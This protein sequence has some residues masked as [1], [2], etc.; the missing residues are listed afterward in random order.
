MIGG[1]GSAG[2]IGA[3]IFAGDAGAGSACSAGVGSGTAGGG[4]IPVIV[5]EIGAAVGVES[6]GGVGDSG[7]V[8]VGFS[9]AGA[10]AVGMLMVGALTGGTAGNV[11]V[12]VAGNGFAVGIGVNGIG[13]L[14][15][16]GCVVVTAGVVV[17]GVVRS[18]VDFSIGVGVCVGVDSEVGTTVDAFSTVGASSVISYWCA[19][20]FSVFDAGAGV[21]T[22]LSVVAVAPCACLSSAIYDS[23][24]KIAALQSLRCFSGLL[25]GVALKT[26]SSCFFTKRLRI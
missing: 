3:V 26:S 25:K 10:D 24:A 4:V 21:C 2:G 13:G 18:G 12:V 11:G 14:V 17:D 8:A 20:S 22:R 9:C 15:G 6:V 1:T 5:G 19:I 7:I 16:H 23:S